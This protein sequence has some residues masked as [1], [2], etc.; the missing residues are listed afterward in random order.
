M[1]IVGCSSSQETKKL[2]SISSNSIN[3][4]ADGISVINIK[5]EPNGED[6][7]EKLKQFG[8]PIAQQLQSKLLHEGMYI[9]R[10]STVDVPA[11][12]ASV[13]VVIEETSVWHGQIFKWRDL[14]QRRIESQGMLISEQGIPYYIQE[15]YLSLLGRSWLLEREDGLHLYLQF[16]PT[17]H[18][19]QQQ[20]TFVGNSNSPLK[21]K[22]FRSLEF[23]TLLQDDEAIIVA[24]QLFAPQVK[25]GPQDEGPPPVRLGEALLGGPV[26]KDIVQILVIEAN[27]MPRG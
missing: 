3:A 2:V 11:L 17:W 9:R 20:S 4:T 21:S 19:P 14:H 13:G 23:E 12:V 25:L 26:I 6:L 5:I 18:V 7:S 27:I 8:Q 22:V 10:V 1:T 16:L 15:G 24:T